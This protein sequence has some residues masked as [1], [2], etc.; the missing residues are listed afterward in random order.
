MPEVANLTWRDFDAA[1]AETDLGIIP[2]GACETYGPH[3]PLSSDIIVA[4]GV[5]RLVARETNGLMSPV[6]PYGDSRPLA[7]FPGTLTVSTAT[8]RNYLA[9]V[10]RSLIGWGMRRILFVNTQFP[11][12][13]VIND[14][15]YDLEGEHNVRCAQVDVWRFIQAFTKDMLE[16]GQHAYAHAGE[17]GTSMLLYFRPDLVQLDRRGRHE[18]APDPFPEVHRPRSYRALAPESMIGDAFLGSREKG[19]ELVRRCVAR[20]V[21]FVNSP[22]FRAPPRPAP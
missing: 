18:P 2:S 7:E 6:I 11:N 22:E 1:R 14:L 21:E 8:L 10:A 4:E 20:I 9:E 17:V 19:E 12:V 5:A 3:L 13:P 15:M 16:G